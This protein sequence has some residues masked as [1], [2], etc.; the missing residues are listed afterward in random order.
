MKDLWA[1]LQAGDTEEEK[2]S[3]S[4]E[5]LERELAH[6]ED[7]GPETT[8]L[9]PPGMPSA[10]SLVVSHAQERMAYETPTVLPPRVSA[11]DAWSL[12]LQNFT[13]SLEQDFLAA[14]SARR[15]TTAVSYTHLTLPTTILV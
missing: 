7:E 3:W 11:A 5:Q 15:Q 14:D 13:S 8:Q 10:A 12:S 2:M 1:D 6:L 4:L 9:P